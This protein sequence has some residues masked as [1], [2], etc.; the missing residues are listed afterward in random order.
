[1]VS[2]VKKTE[3]VVRRRYRNGKV[4]VIITVY[5]VTVGKLRQGYKLV[6]LVTEVVAG[7][8]YVVF[9]QKLLTVSVTSTIFQ[10]LKT[11]HTVLPA[12]GLVGSATVVYTY[13]IIDYTQAQR[14]LPKSIIQKATTIA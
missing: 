14:W 2:S 9:L 10:V 3:H 13:Y 4:G 6:G 11:P 7:E 8:S 5:A 1:M 12:F